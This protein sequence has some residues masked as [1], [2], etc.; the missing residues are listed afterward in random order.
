[1]IKRWLNAFK[2]HEARVTARMEKRARLETL[3]DLVFWVLLFGLFWAYAWWGHIIGPWV[4]NLMGWGPHD[5]DSEGKIRWRQM[6]S[7]AICLPGI[8]GATVLY[9]RN[10]RD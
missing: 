8:I 6:W 3:G 7:T 9:L 5:V 1:M 4:D 10:R 2:L